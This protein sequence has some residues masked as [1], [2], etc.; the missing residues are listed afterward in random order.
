MATAAEQRHEAHLTS[1]PLTAW[2]FIQPSWTDDTATTEATLR[3][4]RQARV[5][6]SSNKQ[7]IQQAASHTP[8]VVC[9]GVMVEQLGNALNDVGS[10]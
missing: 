1:W 6:G 2:R 3:I 7:H 9:I 8:Q 4:D 10:E 5:P